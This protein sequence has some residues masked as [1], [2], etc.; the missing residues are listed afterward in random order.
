MI[1]FST[2]VFSRGHTLEEANSLLD[3]DFLVSVWA[4]P[5]TGSH[6]VGPNKHWKIDNHFCL[7]RND[8]RLTLWQGCNGPAG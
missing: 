7:C 2:V 4:L 8:Q 1:L 6:P 5:K 3:N